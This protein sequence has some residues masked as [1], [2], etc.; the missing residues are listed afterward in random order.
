MKVII[1]SKNVLLLH[2]NPLMIS[3][4]DKNDTELLELVTHTFRRVEN[5][6]IPGIPSLRSK[7]LNLVEVAL[8]CYNNHKEHEDNHYQQR[9]EAHLQFQSKIT[10][11][12]IRTASSTSS[13]QN[14]PNQNHT[15]RSS[16]PSEGNIDTSTTIVPP[17]I[18]SVNGNL[19]SELIQER[20]NTRATSI[21]ETEASPST[22]SRAERV[23]KRHSKSMDET[24]SPT[25][26]KKHPHL[27]E[28]VHH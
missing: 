5:V 22:S 11:P 19:P 10:T 26:K 24:T 9:R 18:P 25:R 8:F 13:E 12:V 4:L 17:P 1:I 7:M 6:D 28:E 15:T 23:N 14:V 2:P 16:S 20:R 3:L 27:K 21:D